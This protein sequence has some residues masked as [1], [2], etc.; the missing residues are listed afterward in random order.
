MGGFKGGVSRGSKG[1]AS[2]GPKKG[3]A[4]RPLSGCPVVDVVKLFLE[5][6]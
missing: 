4:S 1:G 2:R 6:I 3:G 5:E